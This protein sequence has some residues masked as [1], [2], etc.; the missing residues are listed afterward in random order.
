MRGMLAGLARV[1]T[2]QCTTRTLGAG[3]AGR[4]S[5]GGGAQPGRW[6][7]DVLKG[8]A[9]VVHNEDAGC[10]G[11]LVAGL[12]SVVYNEDA[13]CS[14]VLA[15]GPARVETMAGLAAIPPKGQ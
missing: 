2:T 8:Q 3:R 12:A 10:S 4:T 5:Q 9:R 15:A 1:V 6:V 14:G 11:V 13:W 7:Q